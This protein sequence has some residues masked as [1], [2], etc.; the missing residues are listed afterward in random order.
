MA[1]LNGAFQASGKGAVHNR[2]LLMIVIIAAADVIIIIDICYVQKHML[3]L[4]IWDYMH[5][6]LEMRGTGG[7]GTLKRVH[8]SVPARMHSLCQTRFSEPGWLRWPALF[9]FL[10]LAPTS[11][12][13]VCCPLACGYLG[14][15]WLSRLS[16]CLCSIPASSWP[17][18][19]AL[20][21]P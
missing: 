4:Q 6:V 9:E 19:L 1:D 5:G 2:W 12:P 13:C 10:F 20:R 8:V 11:T 18:V 21:S 16:S 17:P 3:L 14:P 15:T 7:A